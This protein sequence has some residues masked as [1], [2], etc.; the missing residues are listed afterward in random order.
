MS[1]LKRKSQKQSLGLSA[2]NNA[3]ILQALKN[4]GNVKRVTY[5]NKAIMYLNGWKVFDNSKI[6]EYSSLKGYVFSDLWQCIYRTFDSHPAIAYP[7]ILGYSIKKEP[8]L[9]EEVVYADIDHCYLQIANKLGYINQRDY[10]RLLKKYSEIKIEIC[11]SFTSL[12]KETKCDYFNKSGRVCR[13]MECNN[14]FL[15]IV[16]DN[17]INYSHS[18]MHEFCKTHQYHVRN[19]DGIWT[20][21]DQASKLNKYLSGLG[22]KFKLHKGKY[23][24]NR[25]IVGLDGKII[26]L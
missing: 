13:S 23:I 8:Q 1:T 19:V 12:F 25:M 3:A 5:G 4:G 22:L 11:A 18:I 17:I 24:N 21:I 6:Q 16:R 2:K 7:A 20:G 14:Y 15:E 9:M 26:Y 10:D